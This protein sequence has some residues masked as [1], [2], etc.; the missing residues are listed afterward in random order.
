LRQSNILTLLVERTQTVRADIHFLLFALIYNRPFVDIGHKAAVDGVHCVTAPVTVERTFAADIAS[1]SHKDSPL[2]KIIA[3]I[4]TGRI[5]PQSFD[6]RKSVRLTG[7][8]KPV[9][10]EGT[11]NG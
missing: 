6:L 2:F 10:L 4:E 5:I 8:G 7:L 11:T 9:K 3:L 1:L